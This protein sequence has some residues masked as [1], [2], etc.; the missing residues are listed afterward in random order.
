V[1]WSAGKAEVKVLDRALWTLFL[2]RH[3]LHAANAAD[4][5]LRK[6]LGTPD[7]ADEFAV[8]VDSFLRDTPWLLALEPDRRARA[9]G[10][11]WRPPSC[12]AFAKWAQRQPERIPSIVWTRYAL[13]CR[14]AA[15]GSTAVPIPH[16][17]PWFAS[18]S[19]PGTTVG[20]HQ[21][22][23]TVAAPDVGA[24]AVLLPSLAPYDE[25]LAI[26]SL[27]YQGKN[28]DP[29]AL[30]AALGARKD[31]SIAVL[32]RL[33]YV[34]DDRAAR[35]ALHE[36]LCELT[37]D[38]CA[39]L[40]EELSFDEEHEAA[41]RAYERALAAA[42]D[43][44]NMSHRMTWL[45]AY[46]F[47]K[48]MP[49]DAE[50]V[51][52]A[53]ADVGSEAGLDLL[54]R[55]LERLGRLAEAETVFREIDMRYNRHA[56]LDLFYLRAQRLEGGSAYADAARRVTDRVFPAGLEKAAL[57][58]F[59]GPPTDGV[60]ILLTSPGVRRLGLAK[61]DVVVAFD[62]HRTRTLLQYQAVRD[63]THDPKITLTVWSVRRAAYVTVEGR[64]LDRR[65]GTTFADYTAAR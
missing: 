29:K 7:A 47:S 62:G 17:L 23:E 35:R 19:L 4:D 53:A 31:Y 3:L 54:G 12:A 48:G 26:V 61:D 6:R 32:Q 21:R 5:H 60:R 49:A 41:A 22:T 43:R 9:E 24:R 25:D 16:P 58:D 15:V 37:A 64:Y 10:V 18:P 36:R 33:A 14:S 56:P 34:E 38:E 55:V 46:Y 51:A 13:E 39:I 11:R 30:A 63:L 2:A 20:A 28:R 27:V 8:Q 50:R 59:S 57:A 52:A 42:R 65:F 1:T 44:V 45:A 40:G